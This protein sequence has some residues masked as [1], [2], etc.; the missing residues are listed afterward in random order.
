MLEL[1][2]NSDAWHAVIAVYG[3]H[4]IKFKLDTGADVTVIPMN[5]FNQLTPY[6]LTNTDACL[7]SATGSTLNV[8]GK[9]EAM[10]TWRSKRCLQ[11]YLSLMTYERR[12]S[13]AT[14]LKLLALYTELKPSLQFQL[15]YAHN[16]LAYSPASA[17]C[18]NRNRM[19]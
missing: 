16:T 5:L 1:A 9:F 11:R 19:K 10:L 3:K 15:T 4:D 2:K 12:N 8:R 6:S 17:A 13:D 7:G 14:Q 18:R